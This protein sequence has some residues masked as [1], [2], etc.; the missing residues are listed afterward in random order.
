MLEQEYPALEYIVQDGGSSDGTGEVLERHAAALAHVE[1]AP[2]KGFSD[3]LNLGFARASG[4]IMAYLNSDDLLLPG[5]VRFIAR[6]FA[7][8]PEIDV[9]YGHRVVIARAGAA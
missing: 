5:A 6:F 9:I 1:A 2:D 4:E 3:A 7:D 8:H